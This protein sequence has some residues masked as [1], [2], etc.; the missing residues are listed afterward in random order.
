MFTLAV[1]RASRQMSLFTLSVLFASLCA[2]SMASAPS[3]GNPSPVASGTNSTALPALSDL[4]IV[5]VT[6]P[7]DYEPF[8]VDWHDPQPAVDV[9]ADINAGN[10]SSWFD[11]YAWVQSNIAAPSVISEPAP[12]ATAPANLTM[13]S[14]QSVLASV[15]TETINSA[16]FASY[17]ALLTSAA[18]AEAAT[19]TPTATP[20]S[21][22]SGTPAAAAKLKGRAYQ[23][24]LAAFPSS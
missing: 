9:D 14:I 15:P 3:S 6:I 7:D 13:S 23:H 4:P 12:N 2:Q 20:G 10:D 24:G 19:E 16:M 5:N 8:S 11:T 18:I 21:V 1:T 22:P 17:E